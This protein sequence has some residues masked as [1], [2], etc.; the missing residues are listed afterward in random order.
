MYKQY[1]KIIMIFLNFFLL[2]NICFSTLFNGHPS[3]SK[4]C[5]GGYWPTFTDQKQI[6]NLFD[7]DWEKLTIANKKDVQRTFYF[8]LIGLTKPK[9]TMQL[10]HISESD[11]HALQ[12]KIDIKLVPYRQDKEY[13][14]EVCHYAFRLKGVPDTLV[15]IGRVETLEDQDKFTRN[16][17]LIKGLEN[18][19]H[20]LSIALAH[21]GPAIS[22]TITAGIQIG[23]TGLPE[24]PDDLQAG[25]DA[26]STPAAEAASHW[27]DFFNALF[28]LNDD[29]DA[30]I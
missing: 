29:E 8:N 17:L 20:D 19:L 10:S 1:P 23:N 11:R 22:S 4:K 21:L 26:V 12:D 2:N 9:Q 7:E 16:G 15:Q 5:E 6:L 13:R 3:G 30:Q 18:H 14:K 24:T 28:G 27:A 25:L